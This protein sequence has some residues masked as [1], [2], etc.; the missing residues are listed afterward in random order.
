MQ[1]KSFSSSGCAV[2][3]RFLRFVRYAQFERMIMKVGLPF[4]LRT[5]E[6]SRRNVSMRYAE[7]PR[8][9]RKRVKKRRRK[10][11]ILRCKSMF[12]VAAQGRY[13]IAILIGFRSSLNVPFIELPHTLHSFA[14]ARPIPLKTRFSC[15]S[16]SSAILSRSRR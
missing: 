4:T 1:F 16:L 7:E 5:V 14:L 13:K 10:R 2:E 6:P 15:R 3:P 12:P 9:V 11:V 8:S